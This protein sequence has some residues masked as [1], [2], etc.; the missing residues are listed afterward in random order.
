MT[1]LPH[2][3]DR[4]GSCDDGADGIPQGCVVCVLTWPPE[5]KGHLLIIRTTNAI[6]LLLN[7]RGSTT[8]K[9]R[10]VFR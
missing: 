9:E 3:V 8:R 2:G 6:R 4:G 5:G 7:I 10:A 1:S